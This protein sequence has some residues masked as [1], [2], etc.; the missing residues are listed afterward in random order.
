MATVVFDVRDAQDRPLT[1]VTV[2]IDGRVLSA[3][4]ND[5]PVPVDPGEHQFQ[6]RIAG[7]AELSRSVT[8]REAEKDRQIRV[9]IQ[10]G[11][12]GEQGTAT[13][14]SPPEKNAR[15]QRTLALASAGL[16]VAG[17]GVGTVFGLTAWSQRN[18]AR[19]ACPETCA[20]RAGVDAWADARR[21]GNFATVSFVVAG[22][23]SAAAA[24]LW[25]TLPSS[26]ATSTRVGL[27]PGSAVLTGAF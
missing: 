22:V 18:E 6:F 21:S 12:T 13:P 14:P 7:Q 10:N 16:A 2:L 23:A 17:V 1:A 8:I 27:G 25:F 3:S 11:A 20:D 24:T 26:S 19:D 4:V 5:E 15:V 9:Q